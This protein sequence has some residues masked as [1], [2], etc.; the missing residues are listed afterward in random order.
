MSSS[1]IGLLVLTLSILVPAVHLAAYVFERLK[2]PRLVGEILVGVL[3]GPFVL[4]VLAPDL[5]ARLFGSTSI[6]VVLDAFYWLGL[7]LLMF[8]SGSETRRLLAAENR[9]ECAWLVAIGTPLPFF[10]VL[11]LGLGGYLPL[12][13]LAGTAQQN[14]SVLLVLAIAVAVTSIPV[15]SRIFYDLGILHTRFASLI[16]GSAVIE[17]IILWAVLAV[18][19]ALAGSATLA[20]THIV[21]DITAHVG[22]T[23]LYMLAG[24]TIVPRLF[25]FA[26]RSRFNF[27]A[28]MSPVAYIL[29]V[30]F[31]YAAVAALLGVNLVFAAFL[32]GFGLV[33]GFKGSH[34]KLFVSPLDSVS[35]VAFAFFIPLYFAIVGY[36][37][38]FGNGFSLS[39]LAV[40]LVGS[41]VLCILAVG[42]AAKLAGFRGLDSVNLAIA[43]NARGGP[44]IVLASVAYE[45]GIINGAFYT[46]LVLTA[47]LT[48]QAAG[49]WLRFVLWKGWPLLSTNPEDTRCEPAIAPAVSDTRELAA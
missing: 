1:E 26:N 7:M 29:T 16:L 48:S 4:G 23:A 41:S 21:G 30:L 12:A 49:T 6:R 43:T 34:R 39:M 36:K 42:L 27:L 38:Q 15:I 17:D 35:K 46:T 3:L 44:G 10:L 47:V 22:A 14:T 28:K 40:F 8:V 13:S 5:S 20:Q 18:A 45:A 24:L 2:Q 33:G 25:R 19:T 37:L 31:G 9:R 11:F 32:A